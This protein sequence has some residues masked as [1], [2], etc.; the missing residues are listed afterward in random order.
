MASEDPSALV[1]KA[2]DPKRRPT[3]RA[4]G[5]ALPLAVE[6]EL[7]RAVARDPS[8]RHAD[9]ATFWA[10]LARTMK[11]TTSSGTMRAV[12]A[13]AASIVPPEPTPPPPEPAL[14]NLEPAPKPAAAAPATESEHIPTKRPPQSTLVGLPPLL[15]NDPPRLEAPRLEAPRVEAPRLEAARVEAPPIAAARAS[16]DT[17]IETTA[18]AIEAPVRAAPRARPI[19]RRTI[20]AGVAV[21][22]VAQIAVA[23]LV[24]RPAP[25]R[26][27]VLAAPRLAH[28]SRFAA[29]VVPPVVSAAP[30]AAPAIA[31][32]PS[33]PFNRFLATVALS[34]INRTLSSC[35][36]EGGLWGTGSAR[37]V[38]GPDGTVTSAYVG[39][40]YN[41][42][43][44]GACV[45]EKL[46]A[47]KV[48]PFAGREGALFYQFF[49]P[50]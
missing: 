21:A 38:F 48:P 6:A 32:T 11:R 47:A 24:F 20:A 45:V 3:P 50:K 28:L 12:T 27:P 25:P 44:E 16:I 35:R 39:V 1:E 31:P 13:S 7:E 42:T 18:P 36:R 2:L 43:P 49:I 30:T 8:R 5:V 41:D 22:A 4:V 33:L 17:P 26:A 9:A 34:N 15:P 10:A 14:P 46:S 40:P 29:P 23:S 37:V 19:T